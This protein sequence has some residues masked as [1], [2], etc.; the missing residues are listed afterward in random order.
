M[1]HLQWKYGGLFP[2]G[3][4]VIFPAR[5]EAIKDAIKAGEDENKSGWKK[6]KRV[7]SSVRAG[8]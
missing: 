8:D 6:R 2:A 3:K 4:S 1:S 7:E 5:W